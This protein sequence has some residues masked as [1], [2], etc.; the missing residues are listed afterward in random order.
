M[1]APLHANS[2]DLERILILIL[3]L[4]HTM[5]QYWAMYALHGAVVTHGD[6]WVTRATPTRASHAQWAAEWFVQ[7]ECMSMPFNH[8]NTDF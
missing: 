1:P 6:T 5:T 3:I 7:N 8:A 2:R 4:E